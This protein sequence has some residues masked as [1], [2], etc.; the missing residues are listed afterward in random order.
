MSQFDRWIERL[1]WRVRWGEFLH[2]AANWLAIYLMVAGGVVL[3]AKL[4]VPR[5]TWPGPLSGEYAAAVGWLL[6]ICGLGAAVPLLV[7]W[8]RS[9]Q[10]RLS[11][12]DLV[13][14]LDRRLGA[15]GLLMTLSET[16]D[17]TDSTDVT[18]TAD[19]SARWSAK[20][21]GQDAA[22]QMSMPLLRPTRFTRYLAVPVLFAMI[23]C[24]VPWRTAYSSSTLRDTVGQR[25]T[26]QL[27]QLL[28]EL[29]QAGVLD[30][31]EQEKLDEEIRKL[32]DDTRRSPLTHEKW[33]TV[34]S[35]REQ[36]QMRLDSTA[37]SLDKALAAVESLESA[38]FDAKGELSKLDQQY[39]EQ[40]LED[41]RDAL[42]NKSLDELPPSLQDLVRRYQRQQSGKGRQ[43]QGKQGKG[44]KGEVG[45]GN[46][47]GG[48]KDGT[49]QGK[50]GGGKKG[51]TGQGQQGQGK[52]SSSGA[53][54]FG[55]PSDPAERQQALQDLKEFLEQE[56]R[57]LEQ[58]QQQAQ[59]NPGGT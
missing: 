34:D 14:W 40:Q 4:L 42:K 52:R 8:R 56:S 11:R 51:E 58:L 37:R 27:V 33:E 54:R 19:A 18:E 43:G 38:E 46:K 16:P 29:K 15:G 32:A 25:E 7:S 55:L 5:E 3:A 49:G 13:A 57:Q 28:E 39:S 50:K 59:R 48:K 9:A 1:A 20:L 30:E 26:Q 6:V 22:W 17:V 47:S 21:P 36:M 35:L 41:I 53:G 10:S 24:V 45:K 44:E 12:T 23:A 2:R 31:K